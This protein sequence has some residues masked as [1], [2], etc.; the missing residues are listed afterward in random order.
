MQKTLLL[1]AFTAISIVFSS[2]SN[3][4]IQDSNQDISVEKVMEMKSKQD[5]EDYLIQVM[6][7]PENF[8]FNL[9]ETRK[10]FK[11]Y[12]KGNEYLSIPKEW[13]SQT[14]SKIKASRQSDLSVNKRQPPIHY[15][16]NSEEYIGGG[17]FVY[18]LDSVYSFSF[19]HDILQVRAEHIAAYSAYGS[20]FASSGG[21]YKGTNVKLL[22]EIGYGVQEELY[23]Y[24]TVTPTYDLLTGWQ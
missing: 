5:A 20:P 22:A 17:A 12:Q 23:E 9:K 2:C 6:E 4:E 15:T 24:T 3:D 16:L 8:G 1:G 14:I 11:V 7:K 18:Y 21:Y 10:D 19:G 13:N